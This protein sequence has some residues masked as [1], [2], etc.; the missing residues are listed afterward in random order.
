MLHL[1]GYDLTLDELKNFRQFG[2][3]N[4]TNTQLSDSELESDPD[5]ATSR[6]GYHDVRPGA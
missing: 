2:S 3:K 4:A 5:I 6:D 1:T